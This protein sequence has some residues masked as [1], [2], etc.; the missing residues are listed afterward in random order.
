MTCALSLVRAQEQ[1]HCKGKQSFYFALPSPQ[2]YAGVHV[3]LR[4]NGAP[5]AGMVRYGTWGKLLFA[6]HDITSH[7][8]GAD[9]NVLFPN[10]RPL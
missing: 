5:T 4:G 2:T 10:S 8:P 6:F 1:V 9:S 7:I 3:N